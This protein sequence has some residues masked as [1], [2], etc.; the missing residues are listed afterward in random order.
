MLLC[1]LR[2]FSANLY[3]KYRAKKR[4]REGKNFI[5]YPIK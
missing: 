3:L 2:W 5:E 4:K 1:V